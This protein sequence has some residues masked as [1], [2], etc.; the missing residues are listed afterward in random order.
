MQGVNTNFNMV[1]NYY[2]VKMSQSGA[3]QLEQPI[4]GFGL[5][6]DALSSL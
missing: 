2:D 1:D 3:L 5:F 6:K 4:F